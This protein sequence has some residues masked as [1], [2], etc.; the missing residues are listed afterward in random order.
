MGV[1]QRVAFFCGI[2]T[3]QCCAAVLGNISRDTIFLRCYAAS[4][5]SMLTLLLSFSSAYALTSVNQFLTRLA[6]KNVTSSVLYTLCPAASACVIF[7]LS[8][9]SLCFPFLERLVSVLIYV[10]HEIAVQLI[11]QQFWDLCAKAFDVSQSKK[12]FG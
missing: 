3:L 12:Y 8:L 7:F 11:A 9:V 6:R 10:C 2:F 1:L 5:I 4:S